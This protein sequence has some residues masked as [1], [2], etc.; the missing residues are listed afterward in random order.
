MPQETDIPAY[1]LALPP[2]VRFGPGRV[3]ETGDIVRLLG[4]RAWLVGG[5]RSLIESSSRPRLEASLEAAGISHTIVA[6]SAGEPTVDQVAAALT[7]LPRDGRDGA[8]IVAVGGG[9]AID[10]AKAVAALATNVGSEATAEDEMAAAVVDHLEGVGSRTITRWP[11]PVVA[12]PTTAG[13]GAEATRNAVVS[14]VRRRFKKSMRSP[15][16]VP[17]A[18]IIDPALCAGCDHATTAATG[19][20]A[21]TQLVESFIC[22]FA[23][24]VPRALVLETLPRAL[25]ALPRV[26]AEPDDLAARAA[27]SHAAFV[28]GVALAN[29]G[30][31]MAHGVAAALGV[32]CG[33]AHGLACALM[34]PIALRVNAVA[35][36]GD[37]A[38]LER[39]MDP[40]AEG[41]DRLLATAFG[42]R[43]ERLCRMAGVPRRLAEVGL[44]RARIPWLAEHSGGASMRGNPVE[45]DAERLRVILE[46]AYAD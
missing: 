46:E 27:L 16:M 33:T 3:A 36:A 43:I 15:L 45:L 34:L 40:A 11:L 2:L 9:S 42:E 21:I 10:L 7:S 25:H 37:L 23:R 14:C 13:T 44:E 19:L 1:D 12:I 32:E 30:L 28:S 17:R 35:A 38:R 26:L 6:E 20:D 39:A 8:V 29:S 24:P 5:R 18:A 4:R 31:G 41:D 22:R